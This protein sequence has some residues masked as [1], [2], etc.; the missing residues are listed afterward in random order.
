M[1]QK[2]KMGIDN[3]GQCGV[4]FRSGQ[5]EPEQYSK[6]HLLK[7]NS[8]INLE[9]E[10]DDGSVVKRLG[11]NY[12]FLP[13]ADKTRPP[14]D[15]AEKFLRTI[16]DAQIAPFLIHCK[17]GRHRTGAAVAIYR[18]AKCQWSFDQAYEEM[19]QFGFYSLFGHKC[20]KQYVE[21]FAKMK[22]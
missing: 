8:I 10:Y 5:I 2:I 16:G 6:L 4:L 21:D 20:F 3:L 1:G 13:L 18:I 14:D 15:F 12:I 9:Q 19:K 11:F 22:V 17:G 7:I